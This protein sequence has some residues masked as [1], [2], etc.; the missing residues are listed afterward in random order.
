[1]L[2]VTWAATAL[3]FFFFNDTATTEIYTLS[4]HDALP[5][6]REVRLRRRDVAGL[7]SGRDTERHADRLT[8]GVQAGGRQLELDGALA[9]SESGSS[10]RSPRRS[11]SFMSA[12]SSSYASAMDNSSIE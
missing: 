12:G 7:G 8:P 2:S 4:L 11:R 1:M 10:P 9:H 6:S 3:R 5:I